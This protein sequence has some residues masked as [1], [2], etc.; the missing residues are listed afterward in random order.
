MKNTFSS[1]GSLLVHLLLTPAFYLLLL[2]VVGL[3]LSYS[4]DQQ[5]KLSANWPSVNGR[6]IQ[7]EIIEV[8]V[9]K[10]HAANP[11]Q[12]E[13]L[14][15][16]KYSY[17]VG[18]KKYESDQISLAKLE[19]SDRNGVKQILKSNT[20]KAGR[21]T[22]VYYNPENPSQAVLLTPGSQI[23]STYLISYIFCGFLCISGLVLC[24]RQLFGELDWGK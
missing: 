24:I 17:Q 11:Y 20:W 18:Q 8:E 7:T 22:D 1:L 13:Y 15:Y 16:V 10:A 5:S 14:P 3:Y 21:K 12:T 23:E 19:P 6:I 2:G 4:Y 9:K